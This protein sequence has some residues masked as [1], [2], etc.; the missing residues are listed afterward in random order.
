MLATFPR[1]WRGWSAARFDCCGL[2][3]HCTSGTRQVENAAMRVRRRGVPEQDGGRAGFGLGCLRL[4]EG[5]CE[6]P[7]RHENPARRRQ[8]LQ[9]DHVTGLVRGDRLVHHSELE[10]DRRLGEPR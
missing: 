6:Q 9:F 4:R 3:A 2:L 7:S 1:S 10:A 5:S 8:G